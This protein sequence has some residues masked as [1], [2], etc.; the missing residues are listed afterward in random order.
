MD[1]KHLENPACFPLKTL[2]KKTK[3]NKI[4]RGE[5]GSSNALGKPHT[6]M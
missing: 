6:L 3:Q 5:V 1:T 2:A 4:Q